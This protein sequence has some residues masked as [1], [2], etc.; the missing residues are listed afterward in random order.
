[1]LLSKVII[2]PE[3]TNSEKNILLIFLRS[4]YPKKFR[5]IYGQSK[6]EIQA[7]LNIEKFFQNVFV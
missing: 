1:M 7:L 2:K 3:I 4:T 5:Q 6:S